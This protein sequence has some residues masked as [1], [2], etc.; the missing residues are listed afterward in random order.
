M[1]KLGGMADASSPPIA[2]L[3]LG[4]DVPSIKNILE[5]SLSILQD[6]C[7]LSILE[8]DHRKA[9]LLQVL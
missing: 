5:E 3:A 1:I 7:K 6:S 4:A 9:I 8:S 2:V